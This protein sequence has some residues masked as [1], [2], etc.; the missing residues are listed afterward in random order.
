MDVF[1]AIVRALSLLK[2]TVLTQQTAN[3]GLRG[4]FA[5]PLVS[6][7]LVPGKAS[8]GHSQTA[9]YQMEVRQPTD[10]H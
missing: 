9:M 5:T 2:L 4:S 1:N 6:S 10:C 3:P 7:L 8:E